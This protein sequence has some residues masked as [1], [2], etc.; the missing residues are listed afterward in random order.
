MSAQIHGFYYRY[1]P[2]AQS[3]DNSTLLLLHGTGGNENDLIDIGRSLSPSANL[4]G[5]RGKVL[6]RGAP[7]FFRR[8]AEGVFD[9]EDLQFRTAELAA[10]VSDA[11][12]SL[13]FAPDRVIAA[14]YSNGANIAASLLL[15]NAGVLAGAILFRAMVPFVP[16]PLPDLLN[17]PVFLAAGRTDPLIS[18][19]QTEQLAALLQASHS[20][21]T[22]QFRNAGHNLTRT[23]LDEATVWMRANHFA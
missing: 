8:L 22:L 12:A 15:S 17:V 1:V 7:R 16:D 5:I 6:E 21:V 14:G 10:F 18:P 23:D 20:D 4:L 2:S 13:G 19:G 9:M 11:A 3:G